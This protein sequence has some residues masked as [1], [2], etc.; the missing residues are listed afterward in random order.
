[1]ENTK[2][3]KGRV[4]WAAIRKIEGFLKRPEDVDE[5]YVIYGP[6]TDVHIPWPE[7]MTLK[8]AILAW[9]IGEMK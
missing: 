4:S 7:G 2:A 8:E 1:M 5:V 9:A 3:I 6:E